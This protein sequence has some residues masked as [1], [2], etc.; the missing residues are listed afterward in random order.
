MCDLLKALSQFEEKLETNYGVSLNEAIVMCS[1]GDEH[2][3]AG[4]ISERTGLT[5][6]HTSKVIRSAEA[7]GLLLRSSGNEDKRK[8]FFMLTEK[9]QQTLAKIRDEGVEMPEFLQP[10][11]SKYKGH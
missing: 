9:A 6:S 5:P 11:L 4:T 1:I 8:M 3:A 10:L 7:K 2:I